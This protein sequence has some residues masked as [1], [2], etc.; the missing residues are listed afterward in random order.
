MRNGIEKLRGAKPRESLADERHDCVFHRNHSIHN[1][2]VDTD[3]HPRLAHAP[4]H[5]RHD[6]EI[7][8]PHKKDADCQGDVS[9]DNGDSV[10]DAVDL[11]S[12]GH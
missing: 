10:D 5:G 7:E 12:R 4:C 9:P 2:S 8:S 3:G 1:A 11:Q 6:A